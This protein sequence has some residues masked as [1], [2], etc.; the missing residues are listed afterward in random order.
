MRVESKLQWLL[1]VFFLLLVVILL[2]FADNL[3]MALEFFFKVD[4]SARVQYV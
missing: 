1:V 4:L 3:I 2:T